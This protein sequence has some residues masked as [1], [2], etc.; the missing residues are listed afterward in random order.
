[1]DGGP[2]LSLMGYNSVERHIEAVRA[3]CASVDAFALAVR[4][5]ER[6]VRVFLCLL[7]EW[8]RMSDILSAA[9]RSVLLPAPSEEEVEAVFRAVTAAP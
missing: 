6:K 3:R 8:Q 5:H 9:M 7:D 2:T 1:M 4:N